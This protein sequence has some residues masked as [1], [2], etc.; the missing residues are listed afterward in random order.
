MVIDFGAV[1]TALLLGSGAWL[2]RQNNRIESLYQSLVGINGK[3]GALSELKLLNER[4]RTLDS[5]LAGLT[6][7]LTALVRVV[8]QQQTKGG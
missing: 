3:D 5:A 6:A 4:T 8:D 1:N 2:W 7:T